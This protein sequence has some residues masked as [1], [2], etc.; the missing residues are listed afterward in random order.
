MTITYIVAICVL[1]GCAVALHETKRLSIVEN[2]EG[3]D[4]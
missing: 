4:K 3:K 2:N 1:I